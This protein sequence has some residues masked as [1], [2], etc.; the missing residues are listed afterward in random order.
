MRISS[1][2]ATSG[3]VLFIEQDDPAGAASL[4]DI[5]ERSPLPLMDKPFRW[6]AGS[7]WVLGPELPGGAGSGDSGARS[8]AGRDRFLHRHPRHPQERRRR[9]EVRRRRTSA[10]LDSS[11]KRLGCAILILHHISHGNSAKYW[12]DRAAGTFA[13]GAATE[14]QIYIDRFRELDINA[15]ERLV[16]IEGRHIP[17]AAHV[18]RFRAETLDYEHVYEGGA[19]EFWADILDIRS[20][21]G[22]RAIRSEELLPRNR[23]GASD[24]ASPDYPTGS[25][26][27]P[28]A[29]R[30]R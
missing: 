6:I 17:S 11:A 21:F 30:L 3:P 5:I 20:H 23:R 24:S 15:P 7:E 1:R 16:R 29:A 19:A 27:R 22:S 9:G 10:D 13:I 26:G 12:S 4:K 18:L 28:T 2:P 8:T 14:A 25:R